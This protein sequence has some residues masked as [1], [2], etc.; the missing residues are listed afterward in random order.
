MARRPVEMAFP[1]GDIMRRSATPRIVT[2]FGRRGVQVTPASTITESVLPTPSFADVMARQAAAR[3]ARALQMQ[4][5]ARPSM[6]DGGPQLPPPPQRSGLSFTPQSRGML[7]GAAAGLQYA[8]P[9]AQPTS[10]GQGLGV[11]GQAAMEA[12]DAAKAAEAKRQMAEIELGLKAREVAA[13][14]A[15]GAQPFTGT[16]M[17]AQSFR[18][19]LDLSPKMES[20]RATSQEEMTYRLAYGHLARPKV[21]TRE[22]DEGVVTAKVPPIDLSGFYTPEG[23]SAEPEIIGET[24]AKFTGEQ[25]NAAAFANRMVDATSTFED[26]VAGGYDPTNFRDFAAGNLP[27]GLSGFA[28]TPEGQQY[29]AAKKNFITAVLRKESGAAISVAE[30]ETEDVK[31]FPQPG[32]TSATVELKRKAREKAVE[33]MKAQSGPAYDVLFGSGGQDEGIPKGSTFIKRFDGV[34]YYQTPKGK[35]LAVE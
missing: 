34:S 20:G 8:G 13:K 2:D 21:E 26:L 28:L 9:Q 15:K 6:V 25:N 4:Q 1:S 33:S 23:F 12:F 17:T 22:T 16:S 24:K 3:Q 35:I 30:F 19:L 14:E 5:Q 31:Y 10:F 18:V 27:R 29:L 7:A 32:D 11:M